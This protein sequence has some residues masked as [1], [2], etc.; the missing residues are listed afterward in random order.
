M[1][2]SCLNRGASAT[3]MNDIYRIYVNIRGEVYSCCHFTLIP[4]VSVCLNDTSEIRACTVK[5][6][7]V[8]PKK[9]LVHA[10]TG[11]TGTD[12]RSSQN[13]VMSVRKNNHF[14]S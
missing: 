12:G 9:F 5:V 11:F 13:G 1:W 3:E 2:M 6:S 8:C 10:R 4:A 14:L 7:I